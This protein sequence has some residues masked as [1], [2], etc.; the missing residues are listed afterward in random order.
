MDYTWHYNSPLGGITLASDGE[1]L[2]GLWF[3]GQHRFGKGLG[4]EYQDKTLPVFEDTCRWLDTYFNGKDPGFTPPLHPC[5]TTFQKQV[6]EIL[7]TIP[8]GQTTTYSDIARRIPESG[9]RSISARAVGGAVGRNPISIIIPCHRVIGANGRI[10]G[11]AA[12]IDK[13]NRLLQIEQSS[14]FPI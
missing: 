13:K 1:A 14:L 5:A 4:T 9:Y 11:Y 2:I 7:L 6:W 12:G 3:D 8:F 10:T